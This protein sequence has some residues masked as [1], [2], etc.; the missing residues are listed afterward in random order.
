MTTTPDTRQHLQ[1]ILDGQAHPP[2]DPSA[3]ADLIAEAG[4]MGQQALAARVN[5]HPELGGDL[6][7]ADRAWDAAMCVHATRRGFSDE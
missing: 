6:E 3:L 1:A 7:A 5:A 4:I 2:L